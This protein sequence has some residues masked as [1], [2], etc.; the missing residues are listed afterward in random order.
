MAASNMIVYQYHE[1]N[2]IN[3]IVTTLIILGGDWECFY[4]WIEFKG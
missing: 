2:I 3:I 4:L 1:N